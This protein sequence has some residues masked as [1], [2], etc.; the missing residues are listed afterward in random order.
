M[1]ATV[2]WEAKYGENTFNNLNADNTV[3]KKKCNMEKLI[4]FYFLS[5][6][7]LSLLHNRIYTE[8]LDA[9][10]IRWI[11]SSSLRDVVNES[12][13]RTIMCVAR[14]TKEMLE[15]V[16]IPYIEISSTWYAS[17]WWIW[18]TVSCIDSGATI[19]WKM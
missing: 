9:W 15:Q 3:G 6:R 2:R 14:F 1:L 7:M 4:S 17:M 12:D 13:D 10:H 8:S 18:H 19:V 16:H 11:S 5:F